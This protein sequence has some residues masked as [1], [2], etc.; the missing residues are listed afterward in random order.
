[1]KFGIWRFCAALRPTHPISAPRRCV[2]TTS[3]ARAAIR[4]CLRMTMIMQ[5]PPLTANITINGYH[6]LQPNL[7]NNLPKR[8]RLKAEP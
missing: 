4:F 3:V 7:G 8:N 6:A 1:M 2:H 5:Q